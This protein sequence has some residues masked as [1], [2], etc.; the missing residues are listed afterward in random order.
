MFACYPDDNIKTLAEVKEFKA[1]AKPDLY[2]GLKN[3]IIGNIV[4]FPLHFLSDANLFFAKTDKE[5]I[6][7]SINFT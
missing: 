4:R 3:Q 1:T 7:P 6:V 2:E 5:M